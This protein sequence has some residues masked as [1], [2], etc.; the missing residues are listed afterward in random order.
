MHLGLVDVYSG[1]RTQYPSLQTPPRYPLHFVLKINRV[2]LF[3]Y[4]EHFIF[5]QLMSSHFLLM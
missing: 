3:N 4:V 5:L 2:Y 1:T